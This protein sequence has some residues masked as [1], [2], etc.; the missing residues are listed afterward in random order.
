MRVSIMATAGLGLIASCDAIIGPWPLFFAGYPIMVSGIIFTILKTGLI[1]SVKIRLE[2]MAKDAAEREKDAAPSPYTP[3]AYSPSYPEAY[4]PSYSEAYS[5]SYPEAYS[6]SYPEAYSPSYPE[7]Y[8][9]SYSEAYS[10]S[11]PEAYSPSYPESYSPSYSEVYSP[12]YSEPYSRQ[13]VGARHSR[14][15][16]KALEE[17]E[18]VQKLLVSAVTHLDTDGC[19]LKL[20]CHL[21]KKHH[22]AV[23][24]EEKIFLQVFYNSPETL[25]SSYKLLEDTET[26]HVQGVGDTCEEG[27]SQCPLRVEELDRLLQ[28]QVTGCGSFPL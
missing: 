8:S 10:P 15:V 27:F 20:L 7:A 13:T 16:T 9:P 12:S 19:I 22:E 26:G 14:G 2:E 23:T 11:Y 28:Q 4:S 17:V 25:S 24:P 1:I 6:P 21:D 5:P 18:E 3:Q